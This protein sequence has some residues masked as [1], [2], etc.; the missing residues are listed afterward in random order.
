[1]P[2]PFTLFTVSTLTAGLWDITKE[3]AKTLA[4]GVSGNRVDSLVYDN[5][6]K[7]RENLKLYRPDANH[8]LLKA[9]TRSYHQATLQVCALRLDKI[10]ENTDTWFRR[11]LLPNFLS[12]P[13]KLFAREKLITL[14]LHSE[15]A[16]LKA[17]SLDLL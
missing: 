3:V 14:D 13:L 9:I 2:D 15:R 5:W 17:V 12:K 8:D 7:L 1:M 10:G 6:L 4:G 16:L 11:E